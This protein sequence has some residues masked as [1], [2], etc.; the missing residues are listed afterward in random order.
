MKTKFD[1]T[2]IQ[3]NYPGLKHQ[4]LEQYWQ[5]YLL[6]N[7]LNNPQNPLPV[8]VLE[9]FFFE[10]LTSG[11]PLEY[12]FQEKY[13]FKNLFYLNESVLIPRF[14]TEILVEFVL[15][16]MK[17]QKKVKNVKKMS[18]IDI[19]TGSGCIAISIALHHE[20]ESLSMKATDIDEK[21]LEVARYNWQKLHKY[22]DQKITSMDFFIKDR[23]NDESNQYDF[24]C[25]NPP[26]IPENHSGVHWQ[27]KKFEPAKALFLPLKDYGQWFKIFFAQVHLNLKPDGLFIMEGHEDYL[28]ELREFM[29]KLPFSKV[30]LK[31]DYAQKIRFLW[32]IK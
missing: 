26:Y 3:D 5:S 27:V 29:V 19:G 32:A 28:E 18:G 2:K 16:W 10:L 1:I 21:S 13:F 9:I 6:L 4:L 11:K 17:N 20:I 30:E 22:N 8:D 14:E 24:I 15:D 23:L 25:S 12:I 7:Q 31:N